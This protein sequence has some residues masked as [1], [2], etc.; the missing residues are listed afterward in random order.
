MLISIVLSNS[1]SPVALERIT[2]TGK[3]ASRTERAGGGG[4]ICGTDGPG[5][6]HFSTGVGTDGGGGGKLAAID[7]GIIAVEGGGIMAAEGG[8]LMA[9]DGTT[10]MLGSMNPPA[11]GALA[12]TSAYALPGEA[13][14]GFG[15]AGGPL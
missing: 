11:G 10:S 2:P 7:D 6:A 1:S 15:T 14:G 9:S 3:P 5:A 8:G 12:T 13:G 4:G